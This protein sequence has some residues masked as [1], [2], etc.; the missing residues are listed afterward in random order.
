ML[1]RVIYNDGRHDFVNGELLNKLIK[2][3]KISRF[4]R[5]DGWVELNDGPL[6][7]SQSPAFRV[8]ERRGIE[9]STFEILLKQD[10]SGTATQQ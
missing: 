2:A 4:H 3:E 9:K 8:P 1:M 5:S 10:L 7:Q 6:R